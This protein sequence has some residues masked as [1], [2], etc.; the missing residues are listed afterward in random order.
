MIPLSAEKEKAL[1]DALRRG[2]PAAKRS[3]Y[4]QYYR[5]L[6][7][8]CSRYARSDEDVKDLLQDVFIKIFRYRLSAASST[9]RSIS[10]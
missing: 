3:F 4:E 2:K 5:Y 7:A 1:V 8:V 6:A 10:A 9:R